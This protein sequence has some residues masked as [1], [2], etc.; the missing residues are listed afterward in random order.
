M[1]SYASR[2]GSPLGAVLIAP[3][4]MDGE[5]GL[6][7]GSILSG[8]AKTVTRVGFGVRHETAGLDLEFNRLI[9][10]DGEKIPISAR[11]AEVDNGRESVSRNGR[12]HGVRSTGSLCYLLPGRR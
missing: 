3:L 4:I 1:G 8:S 7:A 5:T 11:V 10:P 12:I 9:S 2:A 6:Q